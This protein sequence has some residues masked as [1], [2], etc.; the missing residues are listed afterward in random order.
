[1]KNKARLSTTF[2]YDASNQEMLFQ[3]GDNRFIVTNGH[4]IDTIYISGRKFIPYKNRFLEIRKEE[5][6]EI[7]IDWKIKE[8]YLGK[9]G[10][11][12]Q[13]TQANVDVINTN[14]FQNNVYENQSADVH[15]IVYQNEYAFTYNTKK[16]RFKN[17]KQLIN[18]LPAHKES[19]NEFLKTEKIDFQNIPDIIRLINYCMQLK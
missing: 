8:V 11:Y 3:Q 7:I 10:A 6:G 18:A 5:K 14:Y 13:I 4:E 15:K 9:K 2:N 1:M 12:G 17:Q 19:L 16:I